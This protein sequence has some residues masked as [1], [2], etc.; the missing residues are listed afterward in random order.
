MEI[1]YDSSSSDLVT[2][3]MMPQPVFLG[4]LSEV[5][6]DLSALADDAGGAVVYLAIVATGLATWLQVSEGCFKSREMT[7]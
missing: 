5:Q 1:L 7:P 4:A 6:H 3:A 2:S